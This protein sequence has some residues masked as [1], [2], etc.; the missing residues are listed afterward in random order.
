MLESAAAMPRCIARWARRNAKC[1]GMRGERDRSAPASHTLMRRSL[2]GCG[3]AGLPSVLGSAEAAW[4][5]IPLTGAPIQPPSSRLSSRGTRARVAE[6]QDSELAA[7]GMLQRARYLAKEA[8]DFR[9]AFETYDAIVREHGDLALSE[10][11]RLG[12]ACM[13]FELGQDRSAVVELEDEVVNNVGLAEAHAALASIL[14]KQKRTAFA[15]TQWEVAMEFDAR[16][17]DVDWVKGKVYWGPQLIAALE[18]F[19]ALSVS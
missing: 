18:S 15:E 1:G 12:R 11:A 4:A 16:Y 5:S 19:L 9:G 14:W 7:L 10:Y 6:T 17:K 3:L 13:L 8:G 2:L